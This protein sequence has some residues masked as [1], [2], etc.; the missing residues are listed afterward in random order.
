MTSNHQIRA[1][2]RKVPDLQR[3]F[4]GVF[5]KDQLAGRAPDG[6]F[7]IVNLQDS[8]AGFGT[9]WV[10]VVDFMAVPVYIDPYGVHPPPIIAEFM[11]RSRSRKP[12][13]Y[14]AA[15]Y[16]TLESDQCGEYCVYFIEELWKH[17]TRPAVAMD[18]M[19][20]ELTQHPSAQN[21]KVVS[22]VALRER[23]RRATGQRKS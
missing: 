3:R 16:Q 9:H 21:E 18:R 22:Q 20:D 13:R 19:D 23:G 8:G 14:S 1:Y 6:K 2:F 7:Y 12:W 10:A 15:Q 4:G 17:R 11:S 5:S